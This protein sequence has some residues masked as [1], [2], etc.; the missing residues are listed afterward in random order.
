MVAVFNVSRKSSLLL[1]SLLIVVLASSLV[2]CISVNNSNG[3]SLEN[4]IHV[5]SE[6]EL[7][8]AV[9]NVSNNKSAT[10]ALDNDV[11]LTETLRI[12]DKKDITLTSNK[13]SG[14]YKLFGPDGKYTIYIENGGVLRIDGIIVTHAKGASG[15]GIRVT[16]P[17]PALS[18]NPPSGCLFM[19]NGE[20]SG[21]AADVTP[22]GVWGGGVILDVL[23][24]FD[25]YGGKISNNKAAYYG[26]GIYNSGIFTMYGGEIS[27][28]T[29]TKGG[30][31]ASTGGTF[32]M[33]GGKIS[34]NTA[35]WGGGVFRI[36][37]GFINDGG[38]IAGNTAKNVGNN[39]CIDK[40]DAVYIDDGDGGTSNGG[41][42][43][44]S[45]DGSNG[46]SEG[47]DDGTGGVDDGNN[48]PFGVEGFSLRD[49]V[50]IGVGVA[51]VVVGVAVAVLLFTYKK[52]LEFTKSKSEMKNFG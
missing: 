45:G 43:L 33:F 36:M 39:V 25:M 47:N 6:D 8:N 5:K 31:V 23:C 15:S 37:G 22:Y 26:G 10:I 12:S 17:S 41:S 19:Y 35:D 30:G 18:M 27:G 7:K 11:T 32:R 46:F 44:P 21:N 16:A 4:A 34:G 20:I 9:A 50:F 40:G 29:A 13:D 2:V 14:Y 48:N 49:M 3:T 28:N 38:V 51:I 52:E 24:S 1:A 42:G